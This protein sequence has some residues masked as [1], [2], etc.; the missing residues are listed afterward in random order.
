MIVGAGIVEVHYIEPYPKSLVSRLYHDVIDIAPPHQGTNVGLVGGKVPFRPFVGVAPRRYERAFVA[1]VRGV[2]AALVD[3]DR[4]VASPRGG[5][6][7]SA[8]SER[9]AVAVKAIS[10]ILFTLAKSL[11]ASSDEI[12]AT[13]DAEAG[14]GAQPESVV[15]PAQ[16]ETPEQTPLPLDQPEETGT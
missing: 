6:W 13:S 4:S 12:A 15:E 1:E 5:G 11:D 7:T 8:I 2:G 16:P 10:D 9:E 14:A 3:F